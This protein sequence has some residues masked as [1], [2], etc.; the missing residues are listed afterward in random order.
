MIFQLLNLKMMEIT[1]LLQNELKKMMKKGTSFNKMLM[2][3][4]FEEME[5]IYKET[6]PVIFESIKNIGYD[7]VYAPGLA[8]PE[9]MEKEDTD[10]T[11]AERTDHS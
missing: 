11:S 9:K 1:I 8:V 3:E 7:M 5:R 4:R 10:Q 6:F 2:E